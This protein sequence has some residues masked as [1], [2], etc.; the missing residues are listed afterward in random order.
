MNKDPA[1]AKNAT[2]ILLKISVTFTISFGLNKPVII[3]KVFLIS[4]TV[5]VS[6]LKNPAILRIPSLNARPLI[7]FVT[8]FKLIFLTL[9]PI[10]V[11]PFIIPPATDPI[12]CPA[13]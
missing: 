4:V 10:A 2:P 13:L 11:I 12:S 9:S 5:D 8:V 1:N 7:N 6:S 3:P